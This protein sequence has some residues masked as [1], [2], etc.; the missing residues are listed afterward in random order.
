M[1]PQERG[2]VF[3]V[4]INGL[5]PYQVGLGLLQ[6]FTDRHAVKGSNGGKLMC[7]IPCPLSAETCRGQP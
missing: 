4:P 7:A 3:E 5:S 6:H 1:K 2:L